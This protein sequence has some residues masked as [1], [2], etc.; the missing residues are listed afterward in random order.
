M[1]KLKNF[2]KINF[3][4]L[5]HCAERRSH[6]YNEFSK[7]NI[8]EFTP[9]IFEKY[10]EKDFD[11]RGKL[12]HKTLP[13]LIGCGI[14]HLRAIKNW[15]ESTTEP[16]GFFCEDD[17]SLETV[18]YWN[19]TW[20]EFFNKL[21]KDW[22]CVQLS[23]LQEQLTDINFRKR[24]IYDWTIL[25]YIVKREY[26]KKILA[27][28]F[29]ESYYDFN[30]VD[31][32][33]PPSPEHI[34]YLNGGNVY[35]FPLFV[36][37]I[38]FES[39]NTPKDIHPETYNNHV[40]SYYHVLNWWKTI[41]YQLNLNQIMNTQQPLDIYTEF[42]LNTEDPEI[43]F[44][45][46]LHYHNLGHTASAFTHYFR[47][48]E[49]T[50][51]NLL[52]YECFIRGYMC[53]KSQGNRDFT[54]VYF[55][56][57][58]LTVLPDRPEAYYLLSKHYESKGDWDSCYTIS[59][60]GKK[61]CN[62]N[63]TK[64]R[65]WTEYQGEYSLL[66]QNAAAAWWLSKFDEAWNTFNFI[67]DNFNLP[68]YYINTINN[69]LTNHFKNI[70]NNK[71]YNFKITMPNEIKQTKNVVDCFP[72]YA[73][74]GKEMFELRYNILKD[75]VDYFVIS[76]LNTTHTGIPIEWE[77]KKIIEELDIPKDKIILL[78]IEVPTNNDLPIEQIDRLNC[79]HGNSINRESVRSRCR[80]R[81]QRDAILHIFEKFNDETVFINSDLDEI[82]NPD[83]LEW[84]ANTARQ[85]KNYIIKPPLIYLQGRANLRTYF[86]E[87][88][89]PAPWNEGMFLCL[90]EHYKNTTPT[91]VRSCK[92][93]TYPVGYI[94]QDNKPVQDVGWHFSW[95]GD[96][97][98][99]KI[100]Q[101]SFIHYTDKFSFVA[102]GGYNSEEM[103]KIVLQET[104]EGQIPP[105]GEIDK[106]LKLYDINL[107]P[108]EIFTLNN[109]KKFLLP[110]NNNKI[111]FLSNIEQVLNSIYGFCSVK[112]AS[113][114]T[115]LII[116]HQL[117]TIVEIGV[118]E[119]SSFIPQALAV[120]QNNF[121]RIYAIDSWSQQESL[122]NTID[123][124][125]KRYWGTINHDLFYNNFIN[126]LNTYNVKDFVQ[127][128]KTTSK[129]ASKNFLPF[130]IDLLHI[131]GNHSEEQSLE[132][133]ILYLPLVRKNGYIVFDDIHWIDGGK[134]TTQKAADYL[135]QYC[136]TIEKTT[137]ELG[138]NFIIFQKK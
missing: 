1:N 88:D 106:V 95:M 2:P 53:L 50:N 84:F 16:Y 57:Q 67:L 28:H 123:E 71:K 42:A 35:S 22:D 47:C 121:G 129:D 137:D 64:L 108:K 55:L 41:G 8:T 94:T 100:K 96:A 27:N 120:K 3:I 109:V 113:I 4:S 54:A 87:T 119:G 60:L 127:I 93:T 12:L 18:Q 23:L 72:F 14:S 9:N 122:A 102:G 82:I 78:E 115:D 38:N 40:Q 32:D 116:K 56:K 13:N 6:L 5:K 74:Y 61:F 105:S 68:E 58:A 20:S 130:S 92:L 136:T 80:E 26:A 81:I 66:F 103:N 30:V 76:E 126:L 118:L 33:L 90:K 25:A 46:A 98:I 112:K 124:Q 131:D 138:N 101:E 134:R 104:K 97:N 85:S 45:I 7:Y 51:D 44:K 11:I 132:D 73:K 79:M 128:F 69:N 15:L 125:H 29:K 59:F 114:L 111:T 99:K 63:S 135:Q 48:A 107:L 75:Y 24:N 19:F 31:Y 83:Y 91:K 10:N 37:N 49:R 62:F 86:K 110:D 133:V 43:N 77:A 39:S 70:K 117:Q 36:E 65:E 34:I 21:P 89:I 52:K 17:I